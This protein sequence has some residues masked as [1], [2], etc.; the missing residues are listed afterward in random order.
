MVARTCQT[1]DPPASTS[2]AFPIGM[3]YHNWH[4]PFRSP[5]P[6]LEVQVGAGHRDCGTVARALYI[7]L[8]ICLFVYLFET[9][10]QVP[11]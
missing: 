2:L 4:R 7:Y 10:S 5:A 9:E 6:G 1:G 8:F 3:C 11:G